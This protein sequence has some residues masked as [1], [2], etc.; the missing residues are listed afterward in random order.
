MFE[1]IVVGLEAS[2]GGEAVLASLPG[3]RTLGTRKLTL[4]N[5]VRFEYPSS[6]VNER[7]EDS[8][9]FLEGQ[10]AV[11]EAEGFEVHAEVRVGDPSREILIAARD[12]G[13]SLI[14]VGSR[15]HSRAA[16][17]F[18]G[19]VAWGVVQGAEVPVLVQRVEPASG[20]D[21][22][23]PPLRAIAA[24]DHILFP[25]DWSETADRA[26]AY[27]EAFARLGRASSFLLLHVRSELEEAQSGR[28]TQEESLQGL[29]RIA[30]RLKVAGATRVD[31]ESPSGA[32]FVEIVRRA[33]R[34]QGTLI[35]MGTHGRGLVADAVLGSVSREVVRKSL[36]PVLLVPRK[37]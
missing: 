18:I 3:L 16:D 15:S 19:S 36:S 35:V 7:L 1:H 12:A 6:V 29:Q 5:V 27:V 8:R 14:L 34:K 28:S 30:D 11:L 24:F 31:I 4:V 25:T 2:P 32:P 37:A 23:P 26:Q 22:H 17:A 33:E 20:A 13:A 10:R 21:V 9:G